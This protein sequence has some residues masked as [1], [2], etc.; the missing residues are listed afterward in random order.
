MV[1]VDCLGVV[2]TTMGVLNLIEV[3]VIVPP[4][5]VG[6]HMLSTNIKGLIINSNYN[7]H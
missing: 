3:I 6:F 5:M 7:Y 4:K 2:T 1:V